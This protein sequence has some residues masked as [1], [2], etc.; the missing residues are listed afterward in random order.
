MDQVGLRFFTVY[1]PWGRPDMA[2]WSF[3]RDIIAGTPIRVFNN[4]E[5]EPIL[6]GSTILSLAWS[7]PRCRPPATRA[8][9]APRLQ[10]RQQ[11]PCQ[12]GHFIAVIEDAIGQKGGARSML[13]DAA[14][15]RES[16]LR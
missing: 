9:A 14:G 10:H 7:Q 1:G 8:A 13:P 5:L 15:R 12:L 16:H 2:Y 4:G 3:T 11:P 6:P